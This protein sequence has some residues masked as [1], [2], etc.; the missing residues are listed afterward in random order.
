MAADTR[1]TELPSRSVQVL[2][3]FDAEVITD[4]V[5]LVEDLGRQA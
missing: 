4:Q 3:D 5:G 1:N 2:R